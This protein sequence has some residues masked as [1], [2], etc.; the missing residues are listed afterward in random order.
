VGEF[1][2]TWGLDDEPTSLGSFANGYKEI[3]HLVHRNATGDFFLAPRELMHA[4]HGYPEV[5]QNIHVDGLMSFLGLAPRM[6]MI[7][8]M[9]SYSKFTS[10]HLA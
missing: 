10:D 8:M 3:V 2:H 1:V 4:A 5:P 9:M 6:L 7:L